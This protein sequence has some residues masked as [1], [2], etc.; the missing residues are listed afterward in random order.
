MT[1]RR[2]ETTEATKG[3]SEELLIEQAQAAH[4]LGITRQ[5][6]GVWAQRPGAPV[7]MRNGKRLLRWPAFPRWRERELERQVRAESRSPRLAAA[8]ERYEV[9][10]ARKMELETEALEGTLVP[11]ADYEQELNKVVGTL[12]AVASGELMRFERDIVTCQT[13]AEARR[14]TQ[15]IHAALMRGA[16]QAA[17]EL[18]REMGESEQSD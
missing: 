16:N 7:V 13:P 1:T 8:A 14:I 6:L 9:A 17:D 10:R 15:E 5:S 3:Q 2:R 18:E 12:A 4:W 11:L